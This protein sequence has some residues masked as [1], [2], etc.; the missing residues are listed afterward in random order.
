MNEQNQY[1]PK[2]RLLA[3]SKI[4]YLATTTHHQLQCTHCGEDC[5]GN[6]ITMEDKVFCCDGCKTVYSILNEHG[7][8]D[9]YQLN[10]MPGFN[11]RQ[12]ARAGKFQFLDDTAIQQ[13]LISF[14][15][16]GQT[17]VI[18]YLPQIHCSSCLY[19]LENMHKIDKGIIQARVNFS[20]KEVSII[21]KDDAISLR[22]VAEALT[23][24]GYEPYISLQHL[25][26]KKPATSRTMI[27]QLGIAGFCFANIMMLSFPE[28]LGLEKAEQG[29]LLAFRYISFV[30]AIP[31]LLYCAQPFYHAAFT[32]LKKG[33]LNIDAPIVLAILVTYLRSVY[34]V[35]SGTGSGYFDSMS[36]IVFFMLAGRVLQNRTYEQLSFDRDYTS[37]FPLAVSVVKDNIE[38]PTALPDIKHG[39][40]LLIHHEE[41]IP[42]DGIITRG[43]AFIDYSFVT[44]ESLPVR[45]EMG[46][47]VYAGGKQTAGNMEILVIKEVAQSYLTRLWN[48]DDQ[49]PKKD[50]HS[51]VNLLSRY[52]TYIVFAIALFSGLYWA[53]TDSS[54]IWPAVTAVLI[55]ACPCALLLSNSFTNGNLLRILS[56]N[57][58]YLRNSYTIEAIADSSYIVFDK[59]GTLTTNT[60][61]NVQ[62]L[63]DPLSALQLQRIAALAGQSNHPLSKAI[64][65]HLGK[66]DLK[67]MAYKENIAKGIE[68]FI[69]GD[70][71]TLGSSKMIPGAATD[72]AEGA[73][74]HVAIE[75]EYYGFFIIQNRYR[76]GVPALMKELQSNH[77][78]AILSGDNSR[79]RK[80]LEQVTAHQATILFEQMPEDK[81]HFVKKLQQQGEKVMMIGDGLNDAG[82]LKQ[83]EVGISITD[84]T[85]N[86][87][88]AS[89]AILEAGKLHLL[90]KFIA[91]C[92][93]NRHIVMAS[94]IMSIVYNLIGLF[95]AVQGQL[96]PLIAAILMPA[97]SLSI[98]LLTY[99]CSNLLARWWKL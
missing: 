49:E 3:C 28:Y 20:K 60:Q 66:S 34:E 62:Y 95:F 25:Q 85:N 2:H 65:Q 39:D 38:I 7:L 10:T 24:I 21:F 78:I 72:A 98:I 9:Y 23:A 13:Q 63:G 87:T 32:S 47:I 19:L 97:S 86:F 51:F 45:K 43:K 57:G 35:I 41:L 92:Q 15:N 81:L 93:A 74:V 64:V 16:N 27:Y 82:A 77:H 40:T 90:P 94:F 12:Q 69:E 54:K 53:N 79:E 99:G 33:Y 5:F 52:F 91:L 83:S 75:N 44:G 17:Q 89:K 26:Q 29:L 73:K 76:S 46:E 22:G 37:Y 68:G 4:D 61:Q 8:C 70:L 84:N 31:V 71:Y 36:G 11:Q 67:V 56:R 96:S 30:L 59:T 42:A 50:E 55:V 6:A 1:P 58:L 18:F 88:P 48:N 14:R 80:N